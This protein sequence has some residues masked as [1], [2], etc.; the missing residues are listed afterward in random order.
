MFSLRFHY[1]QYSQF[2]ISGQCAQWRFHAPSMED[3]TRSISIHRASIAR[4]FKLNTKR[5]NEKK[6]FLLFPLGNQI[7]QKT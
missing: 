3:N 7:T 6:N 4:P 2:Q 1:G 5:T